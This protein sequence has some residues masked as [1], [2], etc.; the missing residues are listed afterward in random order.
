VNL[1]K[2]LD[3]LETICSHLDNVRIDYRIFFG[4]LLGA[5][6]EKALIAHDS[7]TDIMLVSFNPD[8]LIKI[9]KLLKADGFKRVP[10]NEKEIISYSRNGEVT[11]FYCFKKIEKYFKLWNIIID[12]VLI[13]EWVYL[14]ISNVF[15]KAPKNYID[16][17]IQLY[18]KSWRI[19]IKHYHALPVTLKYG[20]TNSKLLYLLITNIPLFF[21]IFQKIKFNSKSLLKKLSPKLFN[22]LKKTYHRLFN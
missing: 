10:K 17:L 11:D 3:N 22:L 2:A 4:T 20:R 7:D 8:K 18:G 6:R 5:V 13:N 19:P 12:E 21:E 1:K 15:F 9:D 16:C 14:E